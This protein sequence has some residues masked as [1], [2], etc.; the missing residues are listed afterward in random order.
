MCKLEKINKQKIWINTVVSCSYKIS[1]ISLYTECIKESNFH[2]V[3][4]KKSTQSRMLL[5]YGSYWCQN[6]INIVGWEYLLFLS[7]SPSSDFRLIYSLARYTILEAAVFVQR[8][9][10]VNDWCF[11]HLRH[12]VP[13]PNTARMAYLVSF[14]V[15]ILQGET[16]ELSVCG[17]VPGTFQDKL[18][19][20]PHVVPSNQ[21]G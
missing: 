17:C 4:W 3:I 18:E 1:L 19:H 16:L 5:V 20:C 13:S 2:S 12:I 8:K 15:G 7:I 9:S 10:L 14:S 11:W 21:C 6:W